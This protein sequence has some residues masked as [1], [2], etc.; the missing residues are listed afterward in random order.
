MVSIVLESLQNKK[1]HVAL[2]ATKHKTIM[3][4]VKDVIELD[5]NCKKLNGGNNTSVDVS[6]SKNSLESQVIGRPAMALATT[7]RVPML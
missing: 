4:C 1:L 7:Q 6:R 5:E 2:F 3:A